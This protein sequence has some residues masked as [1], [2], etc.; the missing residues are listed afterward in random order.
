MI[1]IDFNHAALLA[2]VIITT[3]S[4]LSQWRS[5]RRMRQLLQRDLERIFEQVDLM[6]FDAQQ[7]PATE[8]VPSAGPAAR[9]AVEDTSLGYAA[10]LELAARG[11]DEAE[12]TARCGLSAPEAR[13]LVAMRG[14]KGNDRNLH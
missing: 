12:I 7:E 13:I 1:R 9:A 4:L 5:F 2:A 10:A 8:A 3:V 14:L 6:R 11:A